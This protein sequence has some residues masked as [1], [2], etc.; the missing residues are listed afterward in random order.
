[1]IS[2]NWFC[3]WWLWMM[4]NNGSKWWLNI[5]L[6]IHHP[7]ELLDKDDWL[8]S[9]LLPVARDFDGCGTT[10][11]LDLKGL[12]LCFLFN[13]SGLTFQG[14]VMCYFCLLSA[15][16][17]ASSQEL[18]RLEVR[19]EI[20]IELVR[21]RKQP[22]WFSHPT[23]PTFCWITSGKNK[24]DHGESFGQGNLVEFFFPHWWLL[25]GLWAGSLGSR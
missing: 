23:Q 22:P 19:G 3:R 25:F 7:E 16:S 20:V 5:Y 21:L 1:M 2:R 14:I 13:I 12:T 10:S 4:K 9:L 24:T 17:P 18:T 6:K 11:S 8:T 15:S